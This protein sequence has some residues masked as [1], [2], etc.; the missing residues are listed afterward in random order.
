MFCLLL[1]KF[2]PVLKDPQRLL[3]KMSRLRLTSLKY[4]PGMLFLDV[5]WVHHYELPYLKCHRFSSVQRYYWQ[6]ELHPEGGNV[7]LHFISFKDYLI[8][9]KAFCFT[10]GLYNRDGK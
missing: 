10:H 8:R 7:R 9:H 4:D 1:L 3:G 6:D 5:S 2:I